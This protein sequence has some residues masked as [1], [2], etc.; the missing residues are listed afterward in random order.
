MIARH[1]SKCGS[2]EFVL[3]SL[4]TSSLPLLGSVT[5]YFYLGLPL[6]YASSGTS[7]TYTM[8]YN[9]LRV[10]W[11]A[12][13][14]W[15]NYSTQLQDHQYALHLFVSTMTSWISCIFLVWVQLIFICSFLC[16]CCMSYFKYDR[17]QEYSLVHNHDGILSIYGIL[18]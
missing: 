12:H 11:N 15:L 13:Q 14:I 9:I 8:S 2:S 18:F 17:A 5:M 4:D 1:G 3:L 10:R 6:N 7:I 16:T